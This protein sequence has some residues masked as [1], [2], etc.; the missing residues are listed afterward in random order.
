MPGL[1]GIDAMRMLKDEGSPA[2]FVFLTFLLK[3]AAGADLLRAIEAV[4][5]GRTYVM[6]Q[7]T[8]EVL[9]LLSAPAAEAPASARCFG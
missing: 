7:I 6:P 9:R 4:M 3:E 2:R 8:K 1:S 5:T